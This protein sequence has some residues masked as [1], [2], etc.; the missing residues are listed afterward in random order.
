MASTRTKIVE[1]ASTAFSDWHRSQ[2]PKS[3]RMID[4]DLVYYEDGVVYAVGEVIHIR[5]GTL[6]DA[7]TE[8]YEIWSHKRRVLENLSARLGV[9]CIVVWATPEA[10]EVVVKNLRSQK[11]RR[12]N[13]DGYAT[14]LRLF[15]DRRGGGG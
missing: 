10:D 2:L 11:V 1:E 5:R 6:E 13:A 14:L 15:R 8:R 7:D 9:P 3:A 12:V 4:C